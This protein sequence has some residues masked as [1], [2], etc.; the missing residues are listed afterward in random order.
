MYTVKEISRMTGI[1][2]RTLRYYDRIGLLPPAGRTEG[3]YRLYDAADME[4]L[5]QILLFR[6]LEFPLQEIQRILS[7]PDFDR[8]RA[9]EQQIGLLELKKEH[10]ENLIL[11]ARGIKLKGTGGLK[12]MDFTA[13]DKE[14][15]DEYAAQA[16]KNWEKTPAWR[17]YEEKKMT[18][19]PGEAG[20]IQR[21]IMAFFVGFGALRDTDP[22][23]EAAQKQVRALQ[24]YITEH[25]YTCTDEILAGLGKL[26]DGG[27]DFTE[28]IDAAGGPGT[29]HFAAQAIE[30]Y[31]KARM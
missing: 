30:C 5:S 27:G 13:F 22:A 28:N 29:A 19:K 21:D 11:L 8:N 24:A 16:R 4:R 17:E 26:Y 7:S 14:K 20:N 1:T 9:L 25:L 10:I 12:L 23:S 15:L 31:C 3:G 6:E 18:W 2:P